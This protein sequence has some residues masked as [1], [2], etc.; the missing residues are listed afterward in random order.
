[1]GWQEV[2]RE[3][4]PAVITKGYELGEEDR[5]ERESRACTLRVA[6]PTSFNR[7]TCSIHAQSRNNFN[8]L[9][10][11]AHKCMA[12]ANDHPFGAAMRPVSSNTFLIAPIL[13][14]M[15]EVTLMFQPDI[16][17]GHKNVSVGAGRSALDLMFCTGQ[18][19]YWSRVAFRRTGKH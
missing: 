12:K 18:R 10:H 13:C 6:A 15:S 14:I 7:K 19:K 1:M 2:L 5:A 8:D 3:R 4:G 9:N 17:H 16:K 11:H